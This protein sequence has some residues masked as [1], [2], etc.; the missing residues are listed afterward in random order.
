MKSY[1]AGSALIFSAFSIVFFLAQP[2]EAN[3]VIRSEETVSL[4]QEQTV[5]GDFYGVGSAVSLSGVIEGDAYVAGGRVTLNGT[6]ASDTLAVGLTA[7][8]QG[9]SGDDVRII[10]G[11]V[12]VSG[13]VRGDLFVIG[14]RLEV[15]S[16][17][18]IDGDVIFFGQEAVIAGSVGHDVLGHMTT[19]RLDGPVA[20]DVTVTVGELTLGERAAIAGAVQYGSG[21]PLVRAPGSVVQG[22]VVQGSG[23]AVNPA[24]RLWTV[25]E[26]TLTLLFAVL[27]WYLLLRRSLESLVAH[28]TT[29]YLRS[30][31]IGLAVLLVMPF[32]AG[33]L[34]ASQLGVFLGGMMLVLY[35]FL[36]CVA[37]VGA[38]AVTGG[39][40]RVLIMPRYTFGLPW[41]LFGAL[42]YGLLLY[43]PFGAVL[44]LLMMVSVTLGA[45]AERIYQMVR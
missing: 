18:Q 7:D 10:A 9:D 31:L 38:V 32:V 26:L 24:Q 45:V 42:L 19:L 16:G 25:A 28:A 23:E 1:F 22:A 8:M 5:E 33:I 34:I 29:H 43:V 17:A 41:L 11:E 39:F 2:A 14:Q 30:G 12:T 13:R 21:S 3:S 35:L 20:H 40:L 4:A 15:L 27:T 37:I 6:V 36:L 44:V